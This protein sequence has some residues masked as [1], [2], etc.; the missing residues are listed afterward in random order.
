MLEVG[1][2]SSA[3]GCRQD[4]HALKEVPTKVWVP[5]KRL[6]Q[7]KTRNENT[8]FPSLWSSETSTLSMTGQQPKLKQGSCWLPWNHLHTPHPDFTE[9]NVRQNSP[10]PGTRLPGSASF[11]GLI[12]RGEVVADRATL[13]LSRRSAA[14]ARSATGPGATNIYS[15]FL[16]AL[17]PGAPKPRPTK[18]GPAYRLGPLGEDR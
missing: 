1:L 6:F 4:Q 18:A 3:Q 17:L 12:S 10:R 5:V 2:V 11:T 16:A 13:L 15:H 14:L 9:L 7:T 8:E